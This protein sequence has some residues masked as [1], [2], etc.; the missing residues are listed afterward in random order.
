M[1]NMD[2]EDCFHYLTYFAKSVED[3]KLRGQKELD[4]KV[5]LL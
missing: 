4:I 5:V 1:Y 2:I 3:A